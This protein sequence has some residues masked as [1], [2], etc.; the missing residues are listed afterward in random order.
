MQDC[1]FEGKAAGDF[2]TG[3]SDSRPDRCADQFNVYIQG[4]GAK[5]HDRDHQESG[6]SGVCLCTVG[7][8]RIYWK[9]S[10]R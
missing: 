10:V 3:D 5:N 1:R 8:S 7:D 9:I 2:R 6:E 4:G